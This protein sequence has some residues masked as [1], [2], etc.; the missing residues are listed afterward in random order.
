MK[1]DQ[2]NFSTFIQD[3]VSKYAN[4]KALGFVDEELMT[5]AEMGRQIDAVKA[6]LEALEIKQGDK[7]AIYS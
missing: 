5:Y 3:V 7:V 6:F 4:N 2:L 1:N